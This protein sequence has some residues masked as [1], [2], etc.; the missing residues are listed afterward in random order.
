MQWFGLVHLNN[1]WFLLCFSRSARTH[2][3]YQ[4][5]IS[6]LKTCNH[7]IKF[8][9]KTR[10]RLTFLTSASKAIDNRQIKV[11]STDNGWNWYECTE[12]NAVDWPTCPLDMHDDMFFACSIR[13]QKR[14]F[15][16]QQKLRKGDIPR[17]FD[18]TLRRQL[19]IFDRKICY[20]QLKA[21]R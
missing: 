20:A 10:R 19:Q 2:S 3:R 1:Q 5:L 6:Y 14:R 18:L 15:S 17:Q 16:D 9:T 8:E 7:W 11:R 12:R 13:A 21:E 4:L